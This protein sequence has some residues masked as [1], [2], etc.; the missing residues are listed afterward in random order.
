L[1]RPYKSTF[2]YTQFQNPN[3]T[4]EEDNERERY[5]QQK[6]REEREE[7]SRIAREIREK[8][9]KGTKDDDIDPEAIEFSASDPLNEHLKKH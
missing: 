7:A 1:E 2:K 8:E 5:L 9:L 6:I 3:K 4:R